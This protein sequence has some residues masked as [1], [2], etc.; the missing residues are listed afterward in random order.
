VPEAR[1]LGRTGVT[2]SLVS[3]VTM[4]GL[5]MAGPSAVTVST[6]GS[7]P[8]RQLGLSV[9]DGVATAVLFVAL[10][11]GASGV[12]ASWLAVRA[13][14]DPDPRRLLGAGI[15]CAALLAVAPPMGSTDIGIYAAFGRMVRLGLNPY[16]HQVSDLLALGDPVGQAYAGVWTGVPSVYG[17]VALAWHWVA[18]LVGGDSARWITWL[19]QLSAAVLFVAIALLLDR[20]ARD[21]GVAARLRVALLWTLNPLLLLE[22]VN[23]AHV[24]VLAILLGV[25][26]LLTVRRSAVVSGALVALA[27]G[28]KVT[29]GLYGAA[30]VWSVRRDGARLL[31][32]LLAAVVTLA[33]VFA[34]VFPEVVDPLRDASRY[35]ASVSVWHPAATLFGDQA[36]AGAGRLLLLLG[37]WTLFALVVWRASTALPGESTDRARVAIRTA[38]LLGLAWLLTATYALPWYDG[39]AW[40]PL[41]LLPASGL[42]LVLLARTTMT[43]VAYLPG[44]TLVTGGVASV[45][46]P[47]R[48]WVAPSVAWV[49]VLLV[50]LAGRRLRLPLPVGSPAPSPPR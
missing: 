50:L 27:L 47:L 24:D 13:G 48:D 33:V 41:V 36:D 2:L 21:D 9:S 20:R 17:P 5:A 45:M 44:A 15:G 29:F 8:G 16:T 35:V 11:L 10:L 12:L 46:G 42:D 40:A 18:A 7:G 26:A 22:L 1:A 32:L 19:L 30:L 14:W 34:P 38:A 6:S 3:V 37:S 43:A 4:A 23:G 39:L 31:R 49:L 25:G 28:V